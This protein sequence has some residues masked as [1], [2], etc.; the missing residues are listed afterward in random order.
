LSSLSACVSNTIIVAT[1]RSY[2]EPVHPTAHSVDPTSPSP[3]R[4]HKKRTD[5]RVRAALALW[6]VSADNMA[7]DR[8]YVLPLVSASL[9][10]SLTER[11][12]W[13]WHAAISSW[14]VR[15]ANMIPKRDV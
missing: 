11:C 1:H 2:D 5:C 3:G 10:K 9:V 12:P 6:I 15:G 7:R 8:S 4:C 14:R 13:T